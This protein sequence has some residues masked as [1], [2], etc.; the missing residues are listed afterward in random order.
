MDSP[1]IRQ[2]LDHTGEDTQIQRQKENTDLKMKAE[3]GV[4]SL[5]AEGMLRVVGST[6]NKRKERNRCSS[7]PSEIA[8]PCGPP[9]LDF[10]PPE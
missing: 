9:D 1:G 4:M 7:E 8:Q 2:A 3:M 6:R 10:W 5:Q